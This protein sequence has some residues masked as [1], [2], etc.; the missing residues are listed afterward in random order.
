MIIFTRHSIAV[1]QGECFLWMGKGVRE[2]FRGSPAWL[3]IQILE[4]FCFHLFLRQSS[5]HIAQVGLHFPSNWDDRYVSTALALESKPGISL[6]DKNGVSCL[7]PQPL[8]YLFC[9]R[10]K[11]HLLQRI[12]KKTYV[13]FQ[14]LFPRV[15]GRA[16]SEWVIRAP[17]W[18][19][20]GL[21]LGG[22]VLM[23]YLGIFWTPFHID[24][25]LGNCS[26]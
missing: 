15:S 4:S 8:K 2:C 12:L 24:L 13:P 25:C 10:T 9:S 22:L 11:N 23:Y 19:L 14:H 20:G 6:S 5:I 1:S 18:L 3:C 7:F 16:V 17:G 21:C 26:Y